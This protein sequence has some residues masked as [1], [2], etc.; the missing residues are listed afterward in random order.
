MGKYRAEQKVGYI[1]RLALF[2]YRRRPKLLLP[3]LP[4]SVVLAFRYRNAG[5]QPANEGKL[6]ACATKNFAVVP[7]LPQARDSFS[8]VICHV[9][10]HTHHDENVA[11]TSCLHAG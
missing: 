4:G 1:C 9:R 2:I 8:R 3:E 10:L 11:Q 6:E 5:F 7:A